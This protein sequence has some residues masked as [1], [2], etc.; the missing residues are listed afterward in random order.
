M[1]AF[2]DSIAVSFSSVEHRLETVS[3]NIANIST[4]GYKRQ[5]GF[6]DLVARMDEARTDGPTGPSA[7]PAALD[8]STGSDL[9]QGALSRTG[10]PLDLAISGDAFFK[11]AIGSSEYL[12]RSGQFRL[13]GDGRVVDAGGMALQVEGGG[14]LVLE[15]DDVE[16]LDDGTVL[17]ED[18]PIARIGLYRAEEGAAVAAVSGTL[19][20]IA[21][22][23]LEGA[24]DSRLHQ[25]MVES[26]NVTLGDEMVSMMALMR[27][28]ES[29]GRLVQVWDQLS[30]KAI[31]AFSLGG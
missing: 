13:G 29:N 10:N 12:T 6:P 1:G 16:I 30:G 27:Q 2:I 17:R 25:G 8:R 18:Y 22:E 14:D 15:D 23:R 20:T 7:S 21:S 26:S 11:V 4:P 3:Q 19:M 5:I 9:G 28:A 24:E 31:D